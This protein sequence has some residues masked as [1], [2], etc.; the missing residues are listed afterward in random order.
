[1]NLYPDLLSQHYAWH[2]HA[3]KIG[4][5]CYTFYMIN[6]LI[7]D[8]HPAV[9]A[10]IAA[11]VG[12]TDG[13]QVVAEAESQASALQACRD[14]NP[15]VVL[16]DLRL[17]TEDGSTVTAAILAQHPDIRVL[18]FTTFD[19]DEVVHRAL[20]AGARGYVLKDSGLDEIERAI[21]SVAAGNRFIPAEIA[22][23]LVLNGP[24]VELTPREYDILGHLADGLRNRDIAARLKIGEATVRTHVQNIIEKFG[25]NDRGAAIAA[26]IARGFLATG[27]RGIGQR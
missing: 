14:F 6:L 5:T 16:M 12:V 4:T 21:C 25:C 7:V 17:G 24:R 8:D 15:D 11:L 9:R 26:A 22:M 13:M 1:M 20:E 19:G 2:E 23:K 3:P 27:E 18:I 10:G